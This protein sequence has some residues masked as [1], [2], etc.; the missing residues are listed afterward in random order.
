MNLSPNLLRRFYAGR[1]SQ[2][3]AACMLFVLAAGV[4]PSKAAAQTA[5]QAFL[6]S[7]VSYSS[8]VAGYKSATCSGGVCRM[9]FTPV[10]AGKRLLVTNVSLNTFS[11]TLNYLGAVLTNGVTSV[12][13]DDYRQINLPGGIVAKNTPSGF[14]YVFNYSGLTSFYIESGYT[15]T[16]VYNGSVLTNELAGMGTITGVLIPVN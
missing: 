6:A 2:L 8:T 15:P 1:L 11:S 9:P 5:D 3:V 7:L 14:G 12:G 4:A 16:M 13:A 10:P